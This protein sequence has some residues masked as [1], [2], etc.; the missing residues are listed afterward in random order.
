VSHKDVLK[1][2]FPLELGG[3][4]DQDLEIEGMHLDEALAR[5]DKLMQEIFPDKADELI[6]DHERVLAI[7]SGSDDPL[8]L[9]RERIVTK[10]KKRGGLSIAYFKALAQEWGYDID[11]EELLPNTDGYGDEGVFRWRVTVNN[12]TGVYYFRAGQSRAGERLLWWTSQTGLEGLF[13]NLK[14]AHTM[15]IFQYA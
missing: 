13:Q 12:S 8:Q 6:P 11:I 3:V 9:R 5:A 4:F 14:P 10:M 15:V 7:T 2:L 1:Q